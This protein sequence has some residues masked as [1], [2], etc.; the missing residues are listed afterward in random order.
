VTCDPSAQR[1]RIISRGA[2]PADAE[3]RIAAQ[4]DLVARLTPAATRV[5]DTTGSLAASRRRVMAAWTEALD[6]PTS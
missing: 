5:I 6:S 2:D 4:S 3:A 1:E